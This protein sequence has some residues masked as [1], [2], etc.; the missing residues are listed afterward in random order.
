MIDDNWAPYYGKFEF[1]KDRFDDP[2]AMI[3]ELH[4][5]GFKVMIWVCPFISPD[6][7]VYRELKSK[8]LLL[9]DNKGDTALTDWNK[10]V[11]PAIVNWWNGNSAVMDFTNPE[12]VNWYMA[13]LDYLTTTYG[14]DGFK[15]DAGDPEFYPAGSI[16]YR[17]ASGN[18][19]TELWGLFGLRYPLNEYRAMWKR[20]GEPLAERLRDKTHSWPDLQKLIP[21]ITSSG[22]LGYAYACPD[23][24]GGGE[25]SSFLNKD[26]LDEELVVRSAQ[27]HALMPMMQFSVAPWRVLSAENLSAV[28][29]AVAL[30]E[31]F[32]PL[33]MQ[34]AEQSTVSG[35]PIVRNM[36]YV[37]PHQQLAQCRDQFMLGDSI[38]V[39]P[40][41]SAGNTRTIVFPK[42]R[43]MGDDGKVVRGPATL[44][45]QVPVDRLPWYRLIGK[46]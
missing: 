27:C 39:A 32:V 4:A 45:V 33:I 44:Q 29:K 7:E 5:M 36:E 10:A 9:L 18:T 40:M 25:F 3:A 15:F 23:M 19:H 1:R 11:E 38:M 16:S 13:Q 14:L 26:R 22:L 28:K 6:S 41:V 17:P 43:W 46:R 42:G 20:A 2:K 8:K 12:A 30:R 21:D 24:I 37:F 35:E 34:L 31:K